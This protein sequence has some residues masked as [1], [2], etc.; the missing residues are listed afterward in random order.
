MKKKYY[1]LL[2]LIFLLSFRFYSSLFY[3]ILNS[4]NG[5]TILMIHYFKLPHDLYFWGQDRMGSMIP[6][7]GQV[8]F[9]IFNLSAVTSESITHYLILLAGFFAFSSFLKSWF[10]KIVFAVIWFFPPFRLIDVTQQYTGIEYSLIAVSCYLMDWYHKKVVKLNLFSRHSL[11]LSIAVLMIASIWVSDMAMVTV[12]LWVAVQLYFYL[13]ENKFSFSVFKKIEFYYALLGAAVGYLFISYAKGI[14]N[15]RTNYTTFSDLNTITETFYIFWQSIFELLTFKANEPFTSVY[16]YLVIIV[17]VLVLSQFKGIKNLGI[18]DIKNKWILFF[19]LD[20]VV[21]FGIIMV[22]KWTVLNDVPRRYFTC[23]Y[24][25]FSFALLLIIENLD[26]KGMFINTIRP[27]LLVA[28]FIGGAGSIYH[29]KY[30][31]P[32]TLKPKVEIV[33]EFQQLGEIGIIGDYWN[34]YI[35]SSTN[36]GMIKATPHDKTAVRNYSLMEEVF[37]Q[38]NIYIIRDMWF[39]SFPDT[40][41]QFNRVLLKDG[42]EFRMGDCNV[43]KYLKVDN[44]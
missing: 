32:Q 29:M 26:V 34:S 6:L 33:G 13:R 5:I 27:I 12:F 8:F 21:L 3:P 35:I 42:Q 39:E 37:Q 15:I 2:G 19:L 36:P 25:S 40:M 24:I 11:L 14:S 18:R 17:L 38:E 44:P 9:K 30:I 43:C 4:D 20:A 23:T 1:I 28:V 16:S 41:V 10:S 7:L 31:W 22:S